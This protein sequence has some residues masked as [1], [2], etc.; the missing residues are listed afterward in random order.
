VCVY[1]FFF[2]DYNLGLG[3]YDQLDCP[4]ARECPHPSP[5]G[6]PR[7]ASHNC[8]VDSDEEYGGLQDARFEVLI[9]LALLVP[10]YKFSRTKSALYLLYSYKST[11]T[12][13]DEA[14]SEAA[15]STHLYHDAPQ[16]TSFTR[17]K[18]RLLT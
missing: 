3:G 17:T 7:K 1:I 5:P 18:V 13:A 16:F 11:F 10:K 2:C 6:A 9:L 14:A 4:D 8:A 12:D 15:L